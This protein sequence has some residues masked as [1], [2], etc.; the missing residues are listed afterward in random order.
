VPSLSTRPR[1]KSNAVP[2]ADKA[3]L[4]VAQS[5]ELAVHDLYLNAIAKAGFSGDELATMQLFADHHLAYVQAIGGLLG[6]DAPFERDDA[7][8]QQ[9]LGATS[10]GA[11]AAR[12][13]QALENTLVATHTDILSRIVGTNGAELVASVIVVEARHA[14]VFGSLPTVSLTSALDNPAVSLLPP[15]TGTAAETTETTTETTVAP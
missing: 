4:N 6:S 10:S 15:A 2:E 9:F 14:A 7:I 13:L 11:T 1:V 5:A 8:Y 12:T 3:L